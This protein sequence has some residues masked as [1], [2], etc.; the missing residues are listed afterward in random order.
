MGSDMHVIKI[1]VLHFGD[2]KQLESLKS[3]EISSTRQYNKL[4]TTQGPKSAATFSNRALIATQAS[5]TEKTREATHINTTK[6]EPDQK[7][8]A[9]A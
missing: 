8:K 2:N 3:W 7:G 1:S 6:K 4:A 5:A 9:R